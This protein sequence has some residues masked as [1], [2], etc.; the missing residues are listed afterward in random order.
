MDAISNFAN[1]TLAVIVLLGVI[2]FFHESG[3][4]LVAKAF[5]MRVFVF[6]F[7]IGRRLFGFKR[8]DTDYR[9]SLLPLGGYV[10]LEG[11]ADDIISE[12]VAARGDGNDFTSRPHWQ[13]LA[14]YLAGP[15]MNAVLAVLV[16]WIMFVVGAPVP[17]VLLETPVVGDVE[18]ASPAATVGFEPADK[19][20]TIDNDKVP[21]WQSAFIAF[22]LRP[23]RD[24]RVVVV[25]DGQ[26]KTFTV[27]PI[28]REETFGDIGVYPLVRIGAI[29]SGGAAEAAGLVSG[30]G[31]L[32]IGGKKIR[33]FLDIPE[34]LAAVGDVATP[35]EVLRDDKRQ[36]I[37]VTPRGGKIGVGNHLVPRR[38]P[39][40]EALKEAVKETWSQTGQMVG[41]IKRLITARVSAKSA[42]SGPVGIAQAAGDA[43]RRSFVEYLSLMALLSV[44]VGVL[45]LFPMAPL[46]GGHI[47]VLLAE[48]VVRRELPEKAKLVFL[49]TGF[50]LVMALMVF[51]LY[52]DLSKLPLLRKILP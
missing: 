42:F 13:R 38:F 9:V 25:R 29:S 26:E 15:A 21:D 5:G 36:T 1:S 45:N 24:V 27:K 46:D 31:I 10:K 35:F 14:V 34:R 18:A 41:L 8:G 12:D 43:V 16:F 20:L 51:I 33:S 3:H 2:I 39:P 32:S 22:G 6:S 37:S 52:S 4:F 28:L 30:D 40:A 7:G 50:V 44:S 49:N 48:M 11:E 19:I 47:A 17:G 23:G